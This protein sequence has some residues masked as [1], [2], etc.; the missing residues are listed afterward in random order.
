MAADATS[1]T[2]SHRQAGRCCGNLG[3]QRRAAGRLVAA[4]PAVRAPLQHRGAGAA[5]VPSV[6][7]QQTSPPR[8]VSRVVSAGPAG[9]AERGSRCV[10]LTLRLLLGGLV[11][12]RR[13]VPLEEREGRLVVRLRAIDVPQHDVLG[14]RVGASRS[15]MPL[16][17]APL[18]RL[19]QRV[20]QP[21]RSE[22]GRRRRDVLDVDIGHLGLTVL[23][24]VHLDVL[25]LLHLLLLAQRC[26]QLGGSLLLN[27]LA[28]RR[29]HHLLKE[30]VRVVLVVEVV[31]PVVGRGGGSA[32]VAV[33][34][35]CGGLPNGNVVDL[36]FSATGVGRHL[37][38]E[39]VRIV[40]VVANGSGLILA[41]VGNHVGN[42]G[43]ITG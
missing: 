24:D 9:P 11:L 6:A 5:V 21:L 33:G 2:P 22:S 26:F 15:N 12:S 7:A 28:L 18:A 25:H 14:A 32:A 16:A 36:V 40:V 43:L 19:C 30:R 34:D 29:L 31:L 23:R 38:E 27:F 1:E 13:Q 10:W 35:G 37:V 20:R 42:F 4:E 8:A 41:H 39:G 3:S 17:A